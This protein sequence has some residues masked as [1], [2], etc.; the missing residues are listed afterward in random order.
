MLSNESKETDASKNDVHV[1]EKL[2]EKQINFARDLIDE[3]HKMHSTPIVKVWPFVKYCCC[4]CLKK[5]KKS[6]N[7]GLKSALRR[8]LEM[9]LPKNAVK[10]EENPFLML[11]YGLNSYFSIV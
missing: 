7:L 10:L 6:F 9:P 4:C 2:D 5:P 11:G 1:N 8:K 3:R